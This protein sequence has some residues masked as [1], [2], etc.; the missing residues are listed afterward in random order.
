MNDDPFAPVTGVGARRKVK[1]AWIFVM[2]VPADAPPPPAAHPKLGAPTARWAYS[3]STGA[4][5]GY[6]LRFDGPE[7]KEFRPLTLWRPAAGGKPVWRWESWPPKR[8]L[9]GLQRLAKRPTAPVVVCEG[10]KAADATTA[11]CRSLWR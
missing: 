1:S 3:D 8:P 10:E 4:A 6:V 11:S 7:G 2:P 9:Y 5:L